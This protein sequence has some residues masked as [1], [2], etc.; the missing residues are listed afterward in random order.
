VSACVESHGCSSPDKNTYV[1]YDRFV[2]QVKEELKPDDKIIEKQEQ[3]LEKSLEVLKSEQNLMQQEHAYYN[4]QLKLFKWSSLKPVVDGHKKAQEVVARDIKM[5]QV[6]ILKV[7]E[8][9]KF[10]KRKNGVRLSQEES[11]QILMELMA[12][13][14]SYPEREPSEQDQVWKLF[15]KMGQYFVYNPEV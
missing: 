1:P 8:E 11:L 7:E 14:Y 9:L 4:R 10:I 2:A 5:F 15:Q 3:Y 12:S 13:G 6:R